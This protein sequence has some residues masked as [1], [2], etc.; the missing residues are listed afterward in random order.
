MDTD[1]K[2]AGKKVMWVED[3]QLLGDVVAK[4]ISNHGATVVRAMD[5]EEAIRVVETEAPDIVVLDILLP[6]ADGFKVLETIKQNPKLMH[7]PVILFSN[8]S[9]R[10]DIEK[11]LSLGA[12]KF[13]VKATI[14]PNEIVDE[15]KGA[16]RIA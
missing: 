9:S 15:I 11:G 8:L 14:V 3:D 4:V 2:L 16:L 6:K 5:G 1:Q 7:I 12:L 13:I 10:E